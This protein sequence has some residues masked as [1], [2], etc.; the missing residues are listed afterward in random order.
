MISLGYEVLTVPFSDNFLSVA[1][2]ELWNL[3]KNHSCETK[4]FTARASHALSK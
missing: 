3:C 2:V 4:G 1:T